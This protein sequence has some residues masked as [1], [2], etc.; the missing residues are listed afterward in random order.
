M[1]ISTHLNARATQ[2]AVTPLQHRLVRVV[3]MLAIA[4]TARE[5][6]QAADVDF[7]TTCRELKVLAAL[8]V[9]RWGRAVHVVREP[10]GLFFCAQNEQAF[11][12]FATRDNGVRP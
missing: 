9:V 6:A 12:A 3:R 4:P 7:P 5:L 2:V 11:S 1:S 10:D 8:G